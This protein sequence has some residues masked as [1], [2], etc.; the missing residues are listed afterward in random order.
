MR[1]SA[2]YQAIL[3]EGRIEGEARGEARGKLAEARRL[4]LLLGEERFGVPDLQ[5]RRAVNRL[6]DLERVERI[7][8]RLLRADGWDDLLATP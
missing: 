8:A 3:R 4:L 1:E 5:T 6:R 7:T 2:T